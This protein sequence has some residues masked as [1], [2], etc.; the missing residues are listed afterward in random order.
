VLLVPAKRT[1]YSADLFVSTDSGPGVRLG[2]E[3]R[4][5]NRK[6]HKLGGDIE[7]SK[8][9]E[10]IGLS[11][12]IP[13]PGPRN[14]MY[15]FATGYRDEETDTSRS[16]T[17]RLAATQSIERWHGYTRT[18]G[19]QFLK[20]DF[21]IADEDRNS[22][23]L[24]AETILTQKRADNLL[25]PR[26][27]R[28]V[29]YG[30]RLAPESPLSDTSLAQI[31][32]EAKWI[33]PMGPDGRLLLRA[34]GGAMAVG[35]FD[36]LPP[37]L[38]FFAGGDRSVRGFDYQAI[39]ETNSTGGVVGGKYLAAASTEYEHYFLESWGA[40]LFVDGGDAFKSQF[41]ANVS[42]GIG[43]RWRSPV[44]LVRIDIAQPVVTDLEDKWRIHLVIGPDL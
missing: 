42:A 38:R 22:S 6:G 13:R 36:D 43:I 4:W 24:Y 27:G 31:R 32:G 9:V 23:L 16:R 21:E 20:G 41:D 3:R 10:E 30:L 5:L 44:G 8:R 1:L 2:I 12:R 29:L 35:N 33:R 34:A 40:A 39:G 15:T 11:Y 14:R 7:Y 25:F 28:S 17:A 19:L 37:E 18:L 26:R